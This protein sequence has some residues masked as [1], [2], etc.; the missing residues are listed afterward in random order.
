MV[1]YVELIVFLMLDLDISYLM[2]KYLNFENVIYLG[3][4]K[5]LFFFVKK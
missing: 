4:L 1:F 2:I 5:I 3:E